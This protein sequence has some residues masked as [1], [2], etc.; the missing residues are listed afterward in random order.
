MIVVDIESKKN[1]KLIQT[2][3][4]PGQLNRGLN[5]QKKTEQALQS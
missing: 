5:I 2:C 3:E 1:K 4:H